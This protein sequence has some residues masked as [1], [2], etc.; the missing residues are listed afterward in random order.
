MRVVGVTET[1]GERRLAQPA[2]GS[3]WSRSI[4]WARRAC[5]TARWMLRSSML[6]GGGGRRLGSRCH[7]GWWG[8]IKVERV[9]LGAFHP[10][11]TTDEWVWNKPSKMG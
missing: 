1:D 11:E 7:D 9:C 2:E 6:S 3:E 5:W 10:L 4:E 8:C